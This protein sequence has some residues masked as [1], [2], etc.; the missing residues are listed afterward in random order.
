MCECGCNKSFNIHN[1]PKS[2]FDKEKKD[3]KK[4]TSMKE[5]ELYVSKKS[6]KKITSKKKNKKKNDL[7]KKSMDLYSNGKNNNKLGGKNKA[8]KRKPNRIN[9]KD[10]SNKIEKIVKSDKK[11][12][13]EFLKKYGGRNRY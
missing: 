6:D 2:F 3:K 9:V 5:T 12:K 1:N 8:V 10:I 13:P 7:K 4:K 11:K